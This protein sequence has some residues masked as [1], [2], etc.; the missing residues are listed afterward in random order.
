MKL[1]IT[2]LTLTLI[3]FTYF[4]FSAF[5]HIDSSARTNG[6]AGGFVGLA[7]D[8]SAVFYNPAGLRQVLVKTVNISYSL[9]YVGLPV[10]GL[11]LAGIGYLHPIE[12][13]GC[14]GLNYVHFG[15]GNLYKENLVYLFYS[16]KLNDF[17]ES[18]ATEI[19]TGINFK[20]LSH[21]YIL[22]EEAKKLAEYLGDPVLTKGTSA[23][24][25][26]L[27][28]G[29]LI[30]LGRITYLGFSFNNVIPAN[31]G[32]YY[33]D[34]VPQDIKTGI[35]FRK[36]LE[37]NKII[38]RFNIN[39][40]IS[41]RAQTWGDFSDRFN[42]HTSLELYFK[43]FPIIL[44]SG[45]NLNNISLGAS[46]SKNISKNKNMNLDFHYSFSLPFRIT[47]NYGIHNISL[48]YSFG[49]PITEKKKEIIEQKIKVKEE[50]LEE[51]FKEETPQQQP[52]QELKKDLLKSTTIQTEQPETEPPQIKQE[53]TPQTTHQ[54][55]IQLK[56]EKSKE[57]KEESVEDDIMKKLLELEKEGTQQ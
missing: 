21:S 25:F 49:S 35:S 14:L 19:Y 45:I 57:I 33:E 22:D 37:D 31:V 2:L 36:P 6:L 26:T 40:D 51:I 29:C 10:E 16:N 5:Q 17:F 4:S 34:I 27:D 38:N 41:Y 54:P 18:L 24:A 9:P 56:K 44:R 23:S 11:S 53:L 50:L 39:C 47:D 42:F 12:A 43:R 8:L 48:Y 28:I 52:P 15:A 32:I 1:N 3:S 46:Y 20:F 7:D 13:L 30:R 55:S